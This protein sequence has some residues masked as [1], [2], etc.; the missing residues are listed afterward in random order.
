MPEIRK[1][2]T[3][4]DI[5][6]EFNNS[7]LENEKVL[8]ALY[9]NATETEWT[10]HPRQRGSQTKLYPL[11]FSDKS[12]QQHI[13]NFQLTLSE[14][15]PNLHNVILKFVDKNGDDLSAAFFA[16]MLNL[17][18]LIFDNT[19]WA[20]L[21]ANEQL[22]TIINDSSH[23]NVL[24][25]YFSQPDA[26]ISYWLITMLHTSYTWLDPDAYTSLFLHNTKAL[27][28][29]W[30][31]PQLYH[32][33]DT[34]V[35]DTKLDQSVMQ[36]LKVQIEIIPD[37]ECD[38]HLSYVIQHT[39]QF[40]VGPLDYCGVAQHVKGRGHDIIMVHE[41][42]PCVNLFYHER[43][44]YALQTAKLK[45]TTGFCKAL[46]SGPITCQLRQRL[47]KTVQLKQPIIDLEDEENVPCPLQESA[48]VH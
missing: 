24:T 6:S 40:T 45:A 31:R 46:L 10:K 48:P 35:C 4:G 27:K 14:V 29:K 8:Q 38:K 2:D 26:V 22:P 1:S 41:A 44:A 20:S 25:E 34:N 42:D 33:Q 16:K 39:K 28:A 15:L 11:K 9:C 37:S 21:I 13:S 43:C 47:D 12:G 7:E 32:I 3:S 5:A 18:P 30:R 17:G 36:P 19:K 23:S